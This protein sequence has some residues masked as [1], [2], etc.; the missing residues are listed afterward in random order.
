[1]EVVGFFVGGALGVGDDYEVRLVQGAVFWQLARAIF[2]RTQF[3]ASHVF[4][5][6]HSC[7]CWRGLL[8]LL[9]VRFGSTA[10]VV[11]EDCGGGGGGDWRRYSSRMSL[12]TSL[13][14]VVWLSFSASSSKGSPGPGFI[15]A[16]L[17]LA[18]ALVPDLSLA[19]GGLPVRG[20]VLQCLSSSRR[21]VEPAALFTRK[22]VVRTCGGVN[23]NAMDDLEALGFTN[24]WRRLCVVAQLC[25]LA[26]HRLRNAT[27]RL[28]LGA[29]RSV[30][31]LLPSRRISWMLSERKGWTREMGRTRVI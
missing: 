23:V 29:Q 1:M 6:G 12:A 13:Q 18:S 2:A 14:G 7:G 30:R 24:L 22:H 9:L 15:R 17:S 19:P 21:S 25:R 27:R 3:F 8:L 4:L 5:S 26:I 11:E 31:S 20:L 10:G 28:L 16:G